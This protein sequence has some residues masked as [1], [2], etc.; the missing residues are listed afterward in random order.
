[1][2]RLN[3]AEYQNVVRDLLA[4][5]VNASDLLPADDG[6]YGF[7]NIAGVLKVSPTLMERYLS[8][9]RTVS[10]LAVGGGPKTPEAVTFR[11]PPGLPQYEHVEG[12][13]F[14]TRG[15]T[16]I[17]YN[18]P[19]DGE[20]EIRVQLQRASGGA[21]SGLN[22]PHEMEMS[23]DGERLKLFNVMPEARGRGAGEEAKTP[24]ATPP[25]ASG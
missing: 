23:L 25:A 13:P 24:A 21:I 19:T 17:S 5:D 2:H 18:F 12:L 3:R 16:M 1:M 20:Y 14:G 10:R 9:A 22:E 6:S 4:L 8:A 11:L 7:D 15:G